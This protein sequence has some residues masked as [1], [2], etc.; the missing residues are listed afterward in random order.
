MEGAFDGC[1]IQVKL[2]SADMVSITGQGTIEISGNQNGVP[3][4]HARD[5]VCEVIPKSFSLSH[6]VRRAI[7]CKLIT[8]QEIKTSSG[9]MNTDMKNPSREHFCQSDLILFADFLIEQDQDPVRSVLWRSTVADVPL[10]ESPFT[11]EAPS[12]LRQ[13]YDIDAVHGGPVSNLMNPC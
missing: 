3:V 7:V 11:C 9:K 1:S 12:G 8:A 10:R 4:R 5:I 2:L 13:D 6:A